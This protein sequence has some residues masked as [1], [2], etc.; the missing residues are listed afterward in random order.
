TPAHPCRWDCASRPRETPARSIDR[1]PTDGFLGQ[2][3]SSPLMALGPCAE[4]VGALLWRHRASGSRAISSETISAAGFPCALAAR[5]R[6]P[7]A[8]A[9]VLSSGSWGWLLS[10][11]AGTIPRG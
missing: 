10:R 1:F 6:R 9:S 5:S 2:Q 3:R 4:G 7:P 8:P 11:A